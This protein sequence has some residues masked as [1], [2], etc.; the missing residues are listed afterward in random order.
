M[1]ECISTITFAL[2]HTKKADG[3]D[4][5][6]A[7][8]V[9]RLCTDRLREFV[10]DPDQN[11]KYLGLVGLVNLMKS[12]PRVVAEHRELVLQCLTDEDVT[13]RTR[14]LELL[15]GMVTRKNLPDIV[16]ALMGHL[17]AAEGHYRDELIDKIIFMC[18]RDKYAYLADFA[19]YIGVLAKL[20]FIQ[21][22]KHS[23]TIAGQ[24]LDVAVRVEDSRPFALQTLLPLLADPVLFQNAKM[25]SG[26]AFGTGSV[27]S[28]AS[29]AAKAGAEMAA[30]AA[31]EGSAVATFASGRAGA[32]Q[33]LYAAAWVVGEYCSII[34]P[35]MHG[36]VIDALLQPSVALLPPAV[37]A[38]YVQ[39][40]LK[41]L[42]AAA[43][44]SSKEGKA[45]QESFLK[46]AA[47]V[48]ERLNPF[49]QSADVEVQERACLV[50][51]LLATLG[52]PYTPIAIATPASTA[53]AKAKAESELMQAMMADDEAKP[54]E[55]AASTSKVP[56]NLPPLE[57]DMR[58]IS[59]VLTS[60]F[61][62]PLKPVNPKAQKKVSVPDGLNLDAW[63]NPAEESAG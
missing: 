8:A 33:V 59:G 51:Q 19:W 4:A 11:L 32:G 56:S 18:S 29:A 7:P 41:I 48:L 14:A 60:L 2:Q 46:L 20:A 17:E 24:L 45:G 44:L 61:S 10:R 35:Q 26:G 62:E 40:A 42:A 36:A 1:Y 54:A 47:S 34:P 13:I 25:E 30:A 15:C 43:N 5:K 53:A 38:V 31:V 27:S 23:A 28:A 57:P 3:T 55:A 6:N 22:T 49:A 12:N 50:Q 9:V 52:I 63:I 21:G 58:L 39:C 16:K 37:Q